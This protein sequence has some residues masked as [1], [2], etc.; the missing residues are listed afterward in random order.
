MLLTKDHND[1]RATEVSEHRRKLF[2]GS[3]LGQTEFIRL[4][5]EASSDMEGAIG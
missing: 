3:N 5:L 1:L 2:E 4:D